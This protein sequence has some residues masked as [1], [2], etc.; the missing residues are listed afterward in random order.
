MNNKKRLLVAGGA[1]FIGS[2]FVN[3]YCAKYDIFVV[4]SLTYAGSLTNFDWSRFPRENFYKEN[5]VQQHQ[6]DKI[7]SEVNPNV[8]VNFAAESHVDNSIKNPSIFTETN[9]QGT[10]TLLHVSLEHGVEKYIQVSTDEVYGHL[11]ADSP[12]FTEVTPLSPRSPYSATKASAD[13]I[14]NAYNQ[15]Y[16]LTTCITRCSNNFGANQHREKLIPKIIINALND[17]KIP[18]YGNGANI[19][20]WIYVEDHIDGIASV[21]EYGKSGNVYNFGGR[22]SEMT[23]LDICKEILNLLDKPFELIEFVEDRKGH[24]FRYSIDYTKATNQLRWEPKWDFTDAMLKT[25]QFYKN[26]T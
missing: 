21:I 18:I 16:G 8:V 13:L 11:E 15:T 1:G 6:M 14:V 24:D 2:N 3:K 23:N 9:V 25:I 26:Y 5:I 22:D 7:F 17:K 10:Q 20:D 19:R 4:D 12:S